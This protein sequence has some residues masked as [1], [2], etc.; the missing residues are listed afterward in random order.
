MEAKITV[1]LSLQQRLAIERFRD[2]QQEDFPSTQAACRHIIE[3]WLTE[4]GFMAP[5]ATDIAG[6]RS[7]DPEDRPD[8]A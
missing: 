4:R 6:E 8:S 2:A 7:Q 1:R 3:T 5:V